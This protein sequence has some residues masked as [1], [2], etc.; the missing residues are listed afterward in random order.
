MDWVGNTERGQCM[1][2]YAQQPCV[3]TRVIVRVMV[4]VRVRVRFR[5]MLAMYSSHV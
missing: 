5:V 4:M 1:Y 3:M 2:G